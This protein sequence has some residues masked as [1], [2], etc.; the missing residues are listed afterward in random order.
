[1]QV[2]RLAAVYAALLAG[3]AVVLCRLYLTA[4]NTRY[5]AR[6]AGPS[7]LTPGRPAPRGGRALGRERPGAGPLPLFGYA[8]CGYGPKIPE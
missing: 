3:V 2:R 7:A 5:A 4:R 6:A 1:M 8:S